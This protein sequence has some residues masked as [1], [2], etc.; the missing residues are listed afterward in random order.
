MV[1]KKAIFLDRDGVINNTIIVNKKPYPPTRMGEI[2]VIDGIKDLIKM[3]HDKGYLV[4][5][6]TNQPDI[7]RNVVN[8]RTVNKINNFLKYE[9][10]FDDLF[11]CPHRDR[12]NCE[13]RKPKTGLFRKASDKY[14]ID[15]KESYMI[16]DRWKDIDAGKRIGCKNLIFIDYNYEEKKPDSQDYTFSS[17]KELLD[18]FYKIWKK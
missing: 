18:N 4:I 7:G 1:D 16:G 9:V 5:V 2:H 6:I 3:W 12:D 11:M 17:I 8:V 10:L 13:C 14:G 15:F